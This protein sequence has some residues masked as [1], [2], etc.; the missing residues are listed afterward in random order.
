MII[1]ALL[2]SWIISRN[3]FRIKKFFHVNKITKFMSDCTIGQTTSNYEEFGIK[4]LNLEL[5][6]EI[7]F[8][9]PYYGHDL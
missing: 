4:L 1:E 5:S 9:V 7:D 6:I 2:K 3:H 8:M